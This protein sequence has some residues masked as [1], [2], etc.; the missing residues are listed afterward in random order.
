MKTYENTFNFELR[1]F[2]GYNWRT[3][4]LDKYR[5][6]MESYYHRITKYL[7]KYKTKPLIYS[8]GCYNDQVC[9]VTLSPL[10]ELHL[11]LLSNKIIRVTLED[12]I[13]N[14]VQLRYDPKYHE[15]HYINRW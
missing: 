10:Y 13:H 4:V 5:E 14:N 3:S 11:H 2:Y 1:D 9:K 12:M 7:M 8:D 6:R 15:I